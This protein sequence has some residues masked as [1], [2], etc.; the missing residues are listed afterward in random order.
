MIFTL[1]LFQYQYKVSV[2]IIM[3]GLSELIKLI[4]IISQPIKTLQ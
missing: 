4:Y 1:Q 2:G 3:K